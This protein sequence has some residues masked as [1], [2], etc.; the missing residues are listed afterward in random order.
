MKTKDKPESKIPTT[1]TNTNKKKL[2]PPEGSEKKL[3]ISLLRKNEFAMILLG[4]L[5]LTLIIFFFFFKSSDSKTELVDKSGSST[6][7]ADFEKRIEALEQAV[8]I[9]GKPGVAGIDKNET[10][11]SG[12]NPLEERVAR[13]EVAFSVKFDSL[14]ERM[15]KIEKSL[16][17]VNANKTAP[18]VIVPKPVAKLSSTPVTPVK[19]ALKK[20]KAAPLF[21]T[22]LKGETLYSISKKYNTSVA[23]LRKLNNLS[24]TASIYPGNNILIR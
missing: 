5:L 14:I 7:A 10:E 20:E 13:L 19:T 16:S 24:S 8:K 22:V 4:A 18:A 1:Q 15:G 23:T 6:S 12:I 2:T 9:Q 21:H 17:Q 11:I 3:N